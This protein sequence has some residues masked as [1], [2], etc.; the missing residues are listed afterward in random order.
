MSLPLKS[1]TGFGSACKEDSGIR[2]QAQ[3]KCVNNKS[4][5]VNVKTR[6]AIGALEKNVRD[7]V[8]KELKRGSIDVFI[9]F[10][11]TEI[12]PSTLI[13]HNIAKAAVNAYKNLAEDYQLEGGV[14]L[15]DVL[16]F[17]GIFDLGDN[18]EF[19]EEECKVLENT[20]QNALEQ[21]AQM[22]IVEG[23][24]TAE[25]L[26]E[27][28]NVVESFMVA[29]KERAPQVIEKVKQKV[30]ERISELENS[31]SGKDLDKQLIEREVMFFADRADIS[32]E[33]DRLE[34]HISQFRDTI[35]AG[36]EAGKKLDFLAQEMLRETNTI[37]SKGNDTEI[38][39]IAIESKL[40]IEKIKEQVANIE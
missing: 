15:A 31:A 1:M 33:V 5:R 37:A 38:A 36:G 21:V 17:P 20:L 24:A 26:N 29:A 7:L 6:P 27:H 12:D 4:L 2:F 40:A 8:T 3:V 14:T 32:E 28:V 18:S 23:K 13:N 25:V 35:T 19:T 16:R 39:T 10:T 9:D 22:R 11:R 30:T 34:S